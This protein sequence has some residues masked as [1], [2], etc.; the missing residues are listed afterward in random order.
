[1]NFLTGTK[2]NNLVISIV[3]GFDRTCSETL[4]THISFDITSHPF[5]ICD[6]VWLCRG[7]VL[8]F[9]LNM[10]AGVK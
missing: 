2:Q 8:L 4:T 9:A 3:Y 5:P 6:Q 1:V 7:W 10:E